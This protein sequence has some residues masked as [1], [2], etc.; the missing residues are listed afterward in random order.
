ME[1][2]EAV[3]K[4]VQAAAAIMEGLSKA[5]PEPVRQDLRAWQAE[6]DAATTAHADEGKRNVERFRAGRGDRHWRR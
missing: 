5:V 3:K 1:E 4:V 2:N 6:Q